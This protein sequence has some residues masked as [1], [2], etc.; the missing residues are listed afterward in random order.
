MCISESNVFNLKLEG[1]LDLPIALWHQKLRDEM[2]PKG[3]VS[4]CDW[5]YTFS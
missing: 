1:S 5:A 2:I 3:T 4:F